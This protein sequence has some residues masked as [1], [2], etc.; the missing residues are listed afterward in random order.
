LILFVNAQ[1]PDGTVLGFYPPTA[2][3]QAFGFDLAKGT[4]AALAVWLIYRG[5]RPKNKT[6]PRLD[7]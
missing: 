7:A 4:I 3:A 1:G 2:S 5:I 6:V